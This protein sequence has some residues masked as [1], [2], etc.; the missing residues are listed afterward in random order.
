VLLLLSLADS[1]KI[2]DVDDDEEEEDDE[3]EGEEEDEDEEDEDEEEEEEEDE[4]LETSHTVI[5][6]RL[7]SKGKVFKRS[8]LNSH[9]LLHDDEPP[10]T[11]CSKLPASSSSLP[12][13]IHVDN[14]FKPGTAG[15]DEPDNK[16]CDKNEKE[17]STQKE[18]MKELLKDVPAGEKVV[19]KK[20]PL[21]P[22]LKTRC[23]G[24]DQDA[25]GEK[26]G[27]EDV[28]V[29]TKKKKVL[30]KRK[31]A[32]LSVLGKSLTDLTDCRHLTREQLMY[33]LQRTRR[34]VV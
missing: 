24:S 7:L 1:I 4:S 11:G 19:K 10:G 25:D 15:A 23:T 6:Q 26:S 3:E 18:L 34:Q 12:P 29:K 2:E 9:Y 5:Q 20:S 16:S 17:E 22:G 30:K 31:V 32:N 14:Y 33:L 8:V 21:P 28:C 27:N 13:D